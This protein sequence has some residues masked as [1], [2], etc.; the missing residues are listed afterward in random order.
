AN[1]V[2]VS[3]Q[4]GSRLGTHSRTKHLWLIMIIFLVFV[5]AGVMLSLDESSVNSAKGTQAEKQRQDQERFKQEAQAATRKAILEDPY[6]YSRTTGEV[7]KP[8]ARKLWKEHSDWDLD[9]C[10]SIADR[11]VA[12]GMMAEQVRL[13]WGKPDRVN[14]TTIR[15]YEQEQWVYG[16]G[17]YLY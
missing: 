11:K 2:V 16:V 12:I 14:T 8:K 1:L 17:E 9:L 7:F 15:G 4:V 3:P 5:A 6:S 13:S 10:Q